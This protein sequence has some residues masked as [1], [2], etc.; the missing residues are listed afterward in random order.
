MSPI[1]VVRH[2]RSTITA[3]KSAPACPKK[4]WALK[5]KIG[6]PVSCIP[7]TVTLSAPIFATK[8]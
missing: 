4:C 5:A 3:N 2:A 7:I 6:A 8:M 1:E